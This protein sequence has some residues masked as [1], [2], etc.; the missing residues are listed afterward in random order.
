MSFVIGRLLDCRLLGFRKKA[1]R[2]GYFYI[3]YS[4]FD[5]ILRAIP[6]IYTEVSTEELQEG[7]PILY[8]I[9]LA[10]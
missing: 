9:K 3:E 5:F 7:K 1:V 8:C 4:V 6:Q 10:L 2:K